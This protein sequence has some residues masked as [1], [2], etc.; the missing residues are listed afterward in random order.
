MKNYY[1]TILLFSHNIMSSNLDIERNTTPNDLIAQATDALNKTEELSEDEQGE[2]TKLEAA[3]RTAANDNLAK[4]GNNASLAKELFEAARKLR[5]MLKPKIIWT[6]EP[7]L[8]IADAFNPPLGHELGEP[9]A[10]QSI[11]AGEITTLLDGKPVRTTA[12]IRY[13]IKVNKDDSRVSQG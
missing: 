6:T 5:L 11:T 8:L 9:I 2:V 7:K 13:G 10:I 12:G 3:L 4:G 1:N